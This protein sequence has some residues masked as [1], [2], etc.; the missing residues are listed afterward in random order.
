MTI[1][2]INEIFGDSCE[3]ENV[4]EMEASISECGYNLPEGGLEEY[5]DYV[6]SEIYESGNFIQLTRNDECNWAGER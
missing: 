4:A 1:T 3:F 6:D 5:Y 2:S